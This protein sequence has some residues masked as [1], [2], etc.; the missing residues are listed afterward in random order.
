MCVNLHRLIETV[1]ANGLKPYTYLHS[2]LKKIILISL[3]S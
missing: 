3:W 1:N 2:V